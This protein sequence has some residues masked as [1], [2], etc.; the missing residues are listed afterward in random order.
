MDLSADLVVEMES[1]LAMARPNFK[2]VLDDSEGTD[3]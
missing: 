3:R 2:F 1:G